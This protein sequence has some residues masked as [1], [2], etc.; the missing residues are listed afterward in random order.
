M[1]PFPHG[2]HLA[3]TN[4]GRKLLERWVKAWAS[5]PL[6][7]FHVISTKTNRNLLMDMLRKSVGRLVKQVA[8]LAKV[9]CELGLLLCA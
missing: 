2:A 8:L 5:S 4:V 6:Q 3:T 7:T 1:L 9:T